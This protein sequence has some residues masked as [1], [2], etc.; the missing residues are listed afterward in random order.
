ML[1]QSLVFIPKLIELGTNDELTIDYLNY[2]IK[3]FIQPNFTY[4]YQRS[5]YEAYN[6]N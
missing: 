2:D 4:H 5:S 1:I 6:N 3:Q